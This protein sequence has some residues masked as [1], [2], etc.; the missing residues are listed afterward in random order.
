M[1]F[2]ESIKDREKIK[3]IKSILYKRFIYAYI[4][5]SFTLG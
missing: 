1:E 2:V 5:N 3:Q 4:L